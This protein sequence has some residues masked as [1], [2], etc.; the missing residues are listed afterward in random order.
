MEKQ[1]VDQA[2]LE[3]ASFKTTDHLRD[4][5]LQE[6]KRHRFALCGRHAQKQLTHVGFHIGVKLHAVIADQVVLLTFLE[7]L[8]LLQ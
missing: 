4:G 6:G 5:L 3:A 8:E 7:R 2:L 1:I